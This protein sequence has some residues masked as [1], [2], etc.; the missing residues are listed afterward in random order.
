MAGEIGQVRM[1]SLYSQYPQQLDSANNDFMANLHFN[2]IRRTGRI[3]G[4][5][6]TAGSPAFRG[7]PET[8]TFESS[9]GPGLVGTAAAAGAGALGAGTGGWY[10][11]S[12]P[13]K[14]LEGKLLN[15]DFYKTIDNAKLNE[16]LELE[17][18][19]FNLVQLAKA[20]DFDSLPEEVKTYLTTNKMNTLTPAQAQQALQ[21][22]GVNPANYNNLDEVL[23]TARN[24][25]RGMQYH[26]NI[27][28][29]N[30][31]FEAVDK[32]ANAD[33]L[34]VIINKNRNFFGITGAT[35]AEIAQQVD[36]L[37]AKGKDGIQ[38]V[39][40]TLKNDATDYIMK[41]EDKIFKHIDPKTGKLLDTADD[42]VKQLFKDFKWQQAKKYGKWGA[43]IAAGGALLYGLFGG[44]SKKQA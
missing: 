23:S 27:L 10:L 37:A 28:G 40:H 12:N 14:D 11:A 31:L 33:E 21:R 29:T 36:Q 26:A 20:T 34:K 6:E 1:D 18:K 44:G 17:T 30:G 22:A 4:I 2:E 13:I 42:T 41:Q 32:A 43:A 5:T 15:L 7:Q 16:V 8:D 24:N 19:R 39:I 25:F 38:D 9:S 3:P 35:E